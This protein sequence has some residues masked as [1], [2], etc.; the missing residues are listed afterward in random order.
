MS[1]TTAATISVREELAVAV[2]KANLIYLGAPEPKP[3][4]FG[5]RWSELEAAIDAALAERNERR[6]R[7]AIA[8]WLAHVER[9]FG[10]GVDNCQQGGGGES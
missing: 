8:E 7:Q 10:A 3:D 5:L 6:A 2:R 4:V 1:A 9:E